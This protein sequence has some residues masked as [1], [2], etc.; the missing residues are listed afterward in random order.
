[1]AQISDITGQCEATAAPITTQPGIYSAILSAKLSNND[2]I[3]VGNGT[4]QHTE[5]EAGDNIDVPGDAIG[6]IFC[7]GV[8]TETALDNVDQG[9]KQFRVS[10]DL[11][12]RVEVGDRILIVN[13]TGNDGFY[14]VNTVAFD[15][16]KTTFTVDET[17]PDATIDGDLS[18]ADK[19]IVFAKG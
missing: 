5:L 18:H 8:P 2:I 17:I 19:A 3:F 15:G 6:A 7:R 13:S 12:S 1:M 10:A 9:L 11:R 4:S 16:S 14:T